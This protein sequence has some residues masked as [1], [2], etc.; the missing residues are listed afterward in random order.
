MSRSLP[1]PRSL[2]TSEPG[3]PLD[4]L[5]LARMNAFAHSTCLT[6]IRDGPFMIGAVLQ[7]DLQIPERYTILREKFFGASRQEF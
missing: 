5:R 7:I 2:D 1:P 6:S 4:A 3:Q